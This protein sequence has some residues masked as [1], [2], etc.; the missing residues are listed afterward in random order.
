MPKE[1]HGKERL[2]RVPYRA[3]KQIVAVREFGIDKYKDEFG[4]LDVDIKEYVEASLRHLYKHLH[5]EQTDPESGLLHIA[6]AAA[7]LLL[8]LDIYEREQE[9]KETNLELPE[10][11]IQTLDKMKG[12]LQKLSDEELVAAQIAQALAFRVVDH[13]VIKRDLQTEYGSDS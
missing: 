1:L 12:N 6:H 8:A 9:T 2:S 7:S 13:E 4:Y 10:D 11:V 5:V 3:L